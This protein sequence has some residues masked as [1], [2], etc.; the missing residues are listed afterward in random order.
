MTKSSG[1]I[2]KKFGRKIF[3]LKNVH[4]HKSDATKQKKKLKDH[5]YLARI[6]KGLRGGWIVWWRQTDK[7]RKWE[8]DFWKRH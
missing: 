7:S 1:S 5:G 3:T 6:T 2:K 4:A 8:K